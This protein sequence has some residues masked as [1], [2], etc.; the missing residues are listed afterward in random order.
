[1][2]P[3]SRI[4]LAVKINL[5][6][7]AAILVVAAGLVGVGYRAYGKRIDEIFVTETLRYSTALADYLNPTVL[8]HFQQ[9]IMSEE[10]Q[11]VRNRAEA[12]GDPSIAETWMAERPSGGGLSGN[13]TLL[14]DYQ[15][16]V[17]ILQYFCDIYDADEAYYQVD[18]DE[19]TW[20]TRS[21]C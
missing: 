16:F 7:I 12:A 11:E 13:Q 15:E 5:L 10:Y 4:S 14:E 21:L 3:E 8:E 6:I 17:F 19:I 1:M 18:K 20:N 2:K 9:E